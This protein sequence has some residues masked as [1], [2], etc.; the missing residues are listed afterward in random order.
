MPEDERLRK[1]ANFGLFGTI[2][3]IIGTMQAHEVIKIITEAGE[4]LSGKLFLFDGFDMQSRIFTFEKNPDNFEL[5][6]WGD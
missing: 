4:V 2:A 3:G 1:S 5:E 6:E